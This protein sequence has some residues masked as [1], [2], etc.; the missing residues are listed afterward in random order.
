MTP[1]DE[2]E[3]AGEAHQG[4]DMSE[5]GQHWGS[6]LDDFLREEGIYEVA[7]V[8]AATRVISWQIAEEMRKRGAITKTQMAERMHTSRAQVDRILKAK[9]NVTIETLQRAAALIGRELRLELV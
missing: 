3:L 9:G 4:D 5:K 2:V 8:E 1:S 6:T 7:K